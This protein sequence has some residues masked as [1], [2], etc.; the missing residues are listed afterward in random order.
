VIDAEF[1]AFV[2]MRTLVAQ[3][4][5]VNSLRSIQWVIGTSN[6]PLA[7]AFPLQALSLVIK[8]GLLYRS[9]EIKIGAWT[10]WGSWGHSPTPW[11]IEPTR[12][13]R[14]RLHRPTYERTPHRKSPLHRAEHLFSGSSADRQR[15]LIIFATNHFCEAPDRKRHAWF[16]LV[17]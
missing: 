10:G 5:S 12:A 16:K 3:P 6:V 7:S 17:T 13:W 9:N 14:R 2:V 11:T 15:P 1:F 4:H 8:G